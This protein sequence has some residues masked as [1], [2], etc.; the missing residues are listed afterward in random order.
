MIGLLLKSQGYDV[1]LVVVDWFSKEVVTTSMQMELSLEGW[2][3]EYITHIFSKHGLSHKV[4]SDRGLQFVS[5]FIRDTYKLLE[6]KGNPSTAYQP[7]TD[8]QTKWINQELEQYLQVFV[9]Y[10][11]EQLVRMVT[12]S[13]LLVQQQNS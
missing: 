10:Q 5:K 3:H 9:N 2:A 8:G 7:Q 12:I 11:T 13:C 6:I 1:I 4:I